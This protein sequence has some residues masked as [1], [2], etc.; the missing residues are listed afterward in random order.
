MD[1]IHISLSAYYPPPSTRQ[2]SPSPGDI[3]PPDPHSSEDAM[4]HMLVLFFIT[5]SISTVVSRT[6]NNLTPTAGAG[7]AGAP[8]P[9]APCAV[10]HFRLSG[11]A[12]STSPPTCHHR[13]PHPYTRVN[14]TVFTG[15]LLPNGN[16]L[17]GCKPPKPAKKRPIWPVQIKP[18]LKRFSKR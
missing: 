10:A 14:Q 15:K 11:S 7:R 3:E 13:S 1:S 2:P 6:P 12:F 18:N 5:A 9:L 4:Q 16:D 17:R 8:S